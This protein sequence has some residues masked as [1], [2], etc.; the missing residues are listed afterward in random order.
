MYVAELA[1][2]FGWSVF[3]GSIGVL[4]GFMIFLTV[5]VLGVWYEERVLD[6]RF[7]DAY[8]AYRNQV[9][10]WLGTRRRHES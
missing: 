6:A 8:R 2:W 10:R 3:Y 9:P 7:G 5:L 4:I 1:L